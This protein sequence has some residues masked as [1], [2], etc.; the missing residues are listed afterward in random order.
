MNKWNNIRGESQGKFIHSV[1][2]F[3]I[4]LVSLSERFSA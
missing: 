3:E 4:A 2:N 1:T